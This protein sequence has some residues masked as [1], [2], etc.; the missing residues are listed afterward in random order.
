[1]R[2]LGFWGNSLSDDR[3]LAASAWS[4]TGAWACVLLLD[5]RLNMF[6]ARAL[7]VLSLARGLALDLGDNLR[8][9]SLDLWA[10]AHGALVATLNL[11]LAATWSRSRS[12][13]GGLGALVTSATI[14]GRGGTILGQDS[15]SLVGVTSW[16]LSW[17]KSSGRW[18]L[19]KSNLRQNDEDNDSKS[20]THDDRLLLWG[21]GGVCKEYIEKQKQKKK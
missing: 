11:L 12:R 19:S 21:V 1:M 17:L 10:F 9:D 6:W 13:G 5:L 8:L 7:V 14:L 18:V 4:G 15:L 3:R 20:N 2:S 16:V